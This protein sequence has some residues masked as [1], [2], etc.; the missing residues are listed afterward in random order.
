MCYPYHERRVFKLPEGPEL[1]TSRD[2]LRDLLID[3]RLHSVN[4]VGGRFKKKPPEN[5]EKFLDE[6]RQKFLIIDEIEVKGKFMWWTI[7]PWRMWCTYGMSG[8]WTQ[9]KDSHAGITLCYGDDLSTIHFRDPRH[10]GTIKFVNDD[11]VHT[12]KL[13]S[14]GPDMLNDPPDAGIFAKRLMKKPQRTIAEVLMDQ[15][16]VA[17]IGN[18]IKAECLHRAGISPHR[19]V[20]A[21]SS[22]DIEKIRSEAINV[23]VESYRS[24]G[25]TISSYRT[26]DGHKGSTQFNFRVYGKKQCQLGHDTVREETLDGRTSHWCPQCQT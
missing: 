10:F 24:Q 8:Q 11:V 16:C 9:K 15:S 5:I 19:T 23:C 25:A 14:L 4:I 20:N 26:V 12:K 13:A 7:G 18:Y 1:T 22:A 2:H 21:L 3:K 6:A 17:G